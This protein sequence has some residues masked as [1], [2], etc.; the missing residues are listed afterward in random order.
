MYSYAMLKN[1]KPVRPRTMRVTEWTPD[2]W[3]RDGD[4][5]ITVKFKT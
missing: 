4:L 3:E 1:K 2:R 5:N